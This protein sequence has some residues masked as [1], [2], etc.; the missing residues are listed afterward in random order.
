MPVRG[1]SK[2]AKQVAPVK[3]EPKIITKNPFEERFLKYLE[4]VAKG[5]SKKVQQVKISKVAEKGAPKI[6]MAFAVFSPNGQAD[7]AADDKENIKII[8]DVLFHYHTADDNPK[9]KPIFIQVL[10]PAEVGNPHILSYQEY[11]FATK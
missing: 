6:D 8:K 5:L 9:A 4:N 3:A 1:E 2:P 11:E 10:L 7:E